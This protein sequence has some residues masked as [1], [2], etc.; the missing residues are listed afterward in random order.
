MSILEDR[1]NMTLIFVVFT[2][3]ILGIG[4]VFT[5]TNIETA[6]DSQYSF[7]L[8]GHPAGLTSMILFC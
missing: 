3:I 6:T 8:I 1:E 2:D 7:P 4:G 5:W